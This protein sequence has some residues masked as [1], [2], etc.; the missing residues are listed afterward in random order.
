M[1]QDMSERSTIED[2]RDESPSP[3]LLHGLEQFNRRE[4]FECHETLEGIWNKE[5]RPIRTLYKGILQVGVGCYHLLRNNYRGATIKL[6]S[7]ARYLEPFAPRS[8]GV[9]VAQLISDARTLHNAITQLGPDHFRE[10]D[11]RL[12]PIVHYDVPK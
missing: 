3:A 5:H 9:D 6:D 8:M 4:Y 11:L 10:V 12:L 2:G 7:G 1:A